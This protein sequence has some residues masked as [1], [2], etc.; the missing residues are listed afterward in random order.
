MYEEDTLNLGCRAPSFRLQDSS[1]AYE[2]RHG[3][4]EEPTFLTYIDIFIMLSLVLALVSAVSVIGAPPPPPAPAG[5]PAG[6]VG[7]GESQICPASKWK[8]WSRAVSMLIR[9]F[10]QRDHVRELA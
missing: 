5:C 2:S 4:R 7:V 1:S 3:A 9:G 6:A 8:F 10:A